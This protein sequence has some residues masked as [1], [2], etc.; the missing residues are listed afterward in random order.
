MLV[1][2][3]SPLRTERGGR[4]YY[5]CSVGCQRTFESPEQEL[6]SMRT[7]VAIAL[8]GVLALAPIAGAALL[9][10]V[11]KRQRRTDAWLAGAVALLVFAAMLA[12]APAEFGREV[13]RWSVD[14][15]PALGL[16]LGFRMDGLAWLFTLLITGIGAL[17]AVGA[18]ATLFGG[19]ESRLPA[20]T[21]AIW[22]GLNLAL[23]M[24]A[25]A[26]VSGAALYFVLHRRV[27]PPRWRR[28]PTSNPA[29]C[30]R[31]PATA[32]VPCAAARGR[33]RLQSGRRALVALHASHRGAVVR[34][35]GAS[36]RCARAITPCHRHPWVGLDHRG[37]PSCP[38]SVPAHQGSCCSQAP[39]ARP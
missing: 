28:H 31:G 8:T 9:A 4:S 3:A 13:L 5:V 7:R 35:P 22:H 33:A 10:F 18:R 21:L 1:D 2:Q 12:T 25:L 15:L 16:K 11:A 38:V 36:A 17:V 19:F 23:G 29:G 6:K 20:G 26:L 24:S 14:W 27:N 34:T 30:R 39:T 32:S 37:E